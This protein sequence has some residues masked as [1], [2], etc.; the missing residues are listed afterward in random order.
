MLQK[1]D[2]H[3]MFYIPRMHFSLLHSPE[4]STLNVSITWLRSWLLSTLMQERHRVQLWLRLWRVRHTGHRWQSQSQDPRLL[5]TS[6]LLKSQQHN[7]HRKPEE[8]PNGKTVYCSRKQGKEWPSR[9]CEQK[10]LLWS[11]GMKSRVPI[12]QIKQ[13]FYAQFLG[14]FL[15]SET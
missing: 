1:A 7:E 12:F 14:D 6:V 4:T 15:Y 5:H 2:N 3:K 8:V 11:G 10:V 13:G 9:G